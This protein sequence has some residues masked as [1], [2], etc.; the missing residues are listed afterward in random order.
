MNIYFKSIT[1]FLAIAFLLQGVLILNSCKKLD[2]LNS[3]ISN[4]EVVETKFFNIP[5][6]TTELT[7][8]VIDEIKKRNDKSGFVT[9]FSNLK[10][11]PVWNKTV[12]LLGN[13]N[14][15]SSI[16]NSNTNNTS[17]SLLYIP[18]VT[19]DMEEFKGYILAKINGTNIALLSTQAKDYKNYSFSNTTGQS[20]ATKFALFN[21]KLNQ[22]VY[23]D[24]VYD[25]T[26]KRLFSTDT[27]H[28]KSNSIKLIPTLTTTGNL[29]SGECITAVL[30][31]SVCNTPNHPN[32]IPNCDHCGGN[33]C[34]TTQGELE[35]CG[36]EYEP[37]IQWPYS[38]GGSSG[39]SGTG[40][41]GG[42]SSIPEYYPCTSS[43][44][45]NPIWSNFNNLSGNTNC[46]AP[47]PGNGW[48]TSAEYLQTLQDIQWINQNVQDSANN[49]CITKVLDTF[50]V[51]RDKLPSLVRGFFGAAPNFNMT[52]KEY[53]DSN[54]TYLSSNDPNPAPPD[55]GKTTPNNLDSNFKVYLNKYYANS[56]N[57]AIAATILHEAF[58]CQLMN[59]YRQADLNN[60]TAKK[61]ELALNYGYLFRPDFDQ[62][63]SLFLI[64]ENSNAGQHADIILRHQ[65]TIAEALFQ[66][67]KK[68]GINVSLSYCKDLS[69]SG[70]TTTPAFRGLPTNVKERIK[71][72]ISAEKDPYFNLFSPT[73]NG[74]NANQIF[75]K[76]KPCN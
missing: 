37:T 22:M 70:C 36:G 60:D 58:H 74:V 25:I 15:N 64:V 16:V 28:K 5:S 50:K 66:F 14:H 29:A 34:Y 76:G 56:T 1:K 13:T 4:K 11:F 57:L 73:G 47:G 48:V 26:D 27:L 62:D 31:S 45:G 33:L 67:A 40:G 35:I 7:K 44:G 75:R 41:G 10:G 53:T 39:G 61:R 72:N 54:W 32:C 52:I 63:N 59:W 21:M 55:V 18:L 71:E 65:N 19:S 24:S 69:W 3:N 2:K 12:F 38:S 51:I 8:R 17:D 6:G 46:P 30:Y 20:E 23:G 68:N 43:S 49:P 9:D 42:G